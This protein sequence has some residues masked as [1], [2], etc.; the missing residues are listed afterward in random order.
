VIER[1]AT[2]P[3]EASDK[4]DVEVPQTLMTPELEDTMVKNHKPQWVDKDNS[5]DSE[6]GIH[7][8][9]LANG[10]RFNYKV[11]REY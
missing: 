9:K 2:A 11:S 10:V 6:T 5:Y 8:K 7:M 3:L 4:Q 1:A